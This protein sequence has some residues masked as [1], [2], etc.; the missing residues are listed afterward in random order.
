MEKKTYF[1]TSALPYVN[2]IPHLG[3]LIGS[4]LSADVYAR[5]KRMT[6][7]KVLYLCGS[8]CYGTQSE[9]KAREEKMTPKEVCEKYHKLHEQTY[10]W[11]NISFDVWGTTMTDTQTKVTHEIFEECYKNGHI[12]EKE[13]QQFYCKQCDIYLAD[14]YLQ[15]ECYHAECTKDKSIT[16]G[17]QCDK[18]GNMIDIDKLIKYW[19][20][21]CKNKPELVTVKHLFLKLG[22]FKDKIHE[23][24]ITDQKCKL[25]DNAISITKTWLDKGLE[26]RC[27]TRNLKWGT[28]IPDMKG[29]E[30]YKDK[31]FYVWFDAPAGYYSIL[32][33]AREDWKD[34]LNGEVVQFMGKDNIAF[35]TVMWPGTLFG[36]SLKYPIVT[37][38][39]STDYLNYEGTKFSKSNKVG[40]FGD[41]V[42]ELSKLLGIDEDYWRYYLIKIRPETK[43]SNFSWNEFVTLIRG[44]L[45]Y[46]VGNYVNRC[47]C[48]SDKYFPNETFT[49]DPNNLETQTITNFLAP[50][51]AVYCYY[52]DN[53]KMRD[54]LSIVLE[55]ADL[56]NG[57]LQ[58]YQPWNL[59]KTNKEQTKTILANSLYIAYI[60]LKLFSP[61]IPRKAE[62]LLKNIVAQRE[63]N[64]FREIDKLDFKI[65]KTDYRM[66]FNQITMQQVDDAKKLLGIK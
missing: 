15:G 26:S 42:E 66:P 45:C 51:I 36:S 18:C 24:F 53:N 49:F 32:K 5:F 19:C 16:N 22:D 2:N 33:H 40:V 41:N 61:F 60:M 9:Q 17:D 21:T 52:L 28:P 44:E 50:K 31:V 30:E 3:N 57:H 47:I 58:E 48:L 27:I 65:D 56:G 20:S 38:I 54:A 37:Q 13:M 8:D 55:I 7:N 63:Y 46:K 43:D 4:T 6:G 14:R 59:I 11:F 29:L 64:V 1:I 10:K 34:W 35:H 23:Y 62:T 12:E 25:S 39:Y